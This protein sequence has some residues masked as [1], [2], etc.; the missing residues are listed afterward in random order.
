[1]ALEWLTLSLSVIRSHRPVEVQRMVQ[2][3]QSA[4]ERRV[5]T[6]KQLAAWQIAENWNAAG[7]ALPEG[8]NVTATDFLEGNS[9]EGGEEEQRKRLMRKFNLDERF[10]WEV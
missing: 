2:G 6:R 1:M 4:Y 9:V 3:T 7:R 8:K 10:G 5:K